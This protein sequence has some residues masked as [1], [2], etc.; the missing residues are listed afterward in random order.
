MA[1]QKLRTI[2]D[3]R[4]FDAATL[5]P[6]SEVATL[7]AVNVQDRVRQ[8]VWRTTGTAGE[9]LIADLGT[10]TDPEDVRPAV[11]V[12]ALINHN[13]TRSATVTLQAA[14][15]NDFSSPQL[16]ETQNAWADIIGAGEGG[17][18]GPFGAGGVL[19]DCQRPWGAPNPLRII[20]LASAPL[21]AK[22]W[23]KIAVNDSDNPDGYL[24]IGRIYLTYYDEYK[25]DWA[26]P[27][28]LGGNDGSQITYNP[29]GV[30][31]TDKWAFQRTLKFG[32]NSRF[33]DVD[34][35]WTLYFMIMKMGLSR[36]WLID[37]IPAGVSSRHFT[38]LFGRLTQIPDLEAWGRDFSNLEIEFQ[39]SL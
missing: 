39:E 22:G 23:W 9:Y 25:Y 8:R 1:K 31:W 27:W 24:Q 16:N 17:A 20:Y 6:S 13:L 38:T 28:T 34:K 29:S 21:Q 10:P 33:R 12:L 35:Y 7:P 32:W 26:F 3:N 30:P 5:Y 19:F 37:P 4:W 14:P 15:T 18:G 11:T 36:D 2:W